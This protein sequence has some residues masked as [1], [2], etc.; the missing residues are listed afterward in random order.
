ME[1]REEGA[2]VQV[3]RMGP[4]G[5]QKAVRDAGEVGIEPR[6][7]KAVKDIYGNPPK[8]KPQKKGTLANLEEEGKY[9]RYI[10]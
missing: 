9:K 8:E 4:N 3:E 1:E 5:T 2:K 10:L 6:E 7:C